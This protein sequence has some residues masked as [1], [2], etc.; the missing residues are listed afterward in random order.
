MIAR[1][2]RGRAT[3]EAARHYVTHVTG[4]VFPKLASIAGHRGATVL[5]RDSGGDV[6]FLVVTYWDSMDA[7]REFAGPTPDVAVVEP[8]ARAILSS[9]D[10]TVHHFGVA[11]A[12]G[13]PR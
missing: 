4:S 3:P 2:W 6:E 5:T 13:G 11:Y 9:F 12:T 10:D 1:M 7:I 8:A